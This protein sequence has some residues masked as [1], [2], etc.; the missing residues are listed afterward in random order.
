M[1][2]VL[3]IITYAF[4]NGFDATFM[5]RH[6]LERMMKKLVPLKLIKD[7]ESIFKVI[8]K[9]SVTTEKFDVLHTHRP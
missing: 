8:V 5:V 9:S 2:S 3:E 6:D 1:R 7:S 4:A